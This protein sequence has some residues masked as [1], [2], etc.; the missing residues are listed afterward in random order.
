MVVARWR[1]RSEKSLRGDKFFRAPFTASYSGSSLQLGSLRKDGEIPRMLKRVTE[2]SPTKL[3]R[4]EDFERVGRAGFLMGR[5]AADDSDPTSSDMESSKRAT[6]MSYSVR[7]QVWRL[8]H[9]VNLASSN[10][11]L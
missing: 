6:T 10:N 9:V 4:V 5:L 2:R 3:E 7:Y 8:S 11:S 1:A